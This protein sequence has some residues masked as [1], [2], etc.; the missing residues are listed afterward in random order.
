MSINSVVCLCVG[1]ASP[2]KTAESVEMQF[3]G[4][5]SYWTWLHM[6]ATYRKRLND[7]SSTAM[8]TVVT[9]IAVTCYFI[10]IK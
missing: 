4:A 1:H 10:A 9:I 6:D 3:L 7:L 5:D 8:R 2:A